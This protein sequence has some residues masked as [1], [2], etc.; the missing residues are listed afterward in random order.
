MGA[1]PMSKGIGIAYILG[2]RRSFFGHA[3]METGIIDHVWSLD[4]VIDL[5]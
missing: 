5:L 1:S 4:E 3:A 2:H